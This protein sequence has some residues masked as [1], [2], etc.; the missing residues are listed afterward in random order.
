MKI[1][2]INIE[3]Y[4]VSN[5]FNNIDVQKRVL[6]KR[7]ENKTTNISKEASIIYETLLNDNIHTI[8]REY[9]FEDCNFKSY[10]PFDFY[11]KSNNSE[12]IIEYDGE[13]HFKPIK[14][15]NTM[16]EY[17]NF[18]KT[19]I[20]DWLKDKFCI[21]NNIPLLRVPYSNKTNMNIDF[22]LNNSK[23]ISS[24][25]NS[26]DKLDVFDINDCDFINYK[27][28]TFI[29]YAGITCSFKCEKEYGKNICHNSY[30][31]NKK[32]INYSIDKCID[33]YKEQSLTHTIT[34]QGLEPLDNLKQV[35]WLIHKV[36]AQCDDIII[37]WTGYTI[38]ECEDLIYLIKDKMNWKNIIFKFGRFIP[39][40]KPHFDEVLGVNLASDNQYGVKIS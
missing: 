16:S 11:V 1:A 28:P 37:I 38:D 25:S 14:F 27:E 39:D 8:E 23:I 31:S 5:L 30:L 2:S 21:E 7:M 12:F 13:Q 19:Q 4:R 35:L 40:Q 22:L 15:S 3:K 24:T 32:P 20:S 6:K 10:L 29:I 18:I 9:V 36:R 26:N 17:K 33:M 34:I